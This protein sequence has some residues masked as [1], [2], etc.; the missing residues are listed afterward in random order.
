MQSLF[1]VIGNTTLWM[2]AYGIYADSKAA[3]Q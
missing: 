1:T 3:A 2:G